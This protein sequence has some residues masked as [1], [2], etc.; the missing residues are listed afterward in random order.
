VY[1]F[2]KGKAN[3]RVLGKPVIKNKVF[4]YLK[5]NRLKEGGMPCG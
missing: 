2:L 1:V 4:L 5:V 3:G